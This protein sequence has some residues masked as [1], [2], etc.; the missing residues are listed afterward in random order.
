MTLRSRLRRRLLIGAAGAT[1][2]LTTLGVAAPAQAAYT[3]GLQQYAGTAGCAMTFASDVCAQTP[4]SLSGQGI[5]RDGD[6]LYLSVGDDNGGAP[7]LFHYRRTAGGITLASCVVSV[8]SEQTDALGCEVVSFL[9]RYATRPA[10]AEDAVYIGGS[11]GEQG[12]TWSGVVAAIPRD[13]ATGDLVALGATC[14]AANA[15]DAPGCT[16]AGLDRLGTD[17]ADVVVAPD[18]LTVHALASTGPETQLV[19]YERV[20]GP[21]NEPGALDPVSC[22][23]NVD[24]SCDRPPANQRVLLNRGNE[25]AIAP[26]GA[27]VYL[28]AQNG[29]VHLARN[30]STGELSIDDCVGDGDDVK[31]LCDKGPGDFLGVS[32]LSMSSDDQVIAIAQGGDSVSVVRLL[33]DAS[34]TLTEAGCIGTAEEDGCGVAVGVISPEAAVATPDDKNVI[35]SNGAGQPLVTLIAGGASGLRPMVGS[36]GCITG[37]QAQPAGCPAD[38]RGGTVREFAPSFPTQ[39]LATDA[40]VVVTNP[41]SMLFFVR[42]RAPGCLQRSATAARPSGALPLV[43]TDPNGD[44]I[45]LVIGR[46]PAHGTLDEISQSGSNVVFTP[47]DTYEGADS[48]TYGAGDGTFTSTAVTY[49]LILPTGPNTVKPTTPTAPTTPPLDDGSN[50]GGGKATDDEPSDKGNGGGG[51][52]VAPGTI[53]TPAPSTPGPTAGPS[54]IDLKTVGKQLTVSSKRIVAFKL[55]CKGEQGAPACKGALRLGAASRLVVDGKRQVVTFGRKD[56]VIP[57]GATFTVSL[58]LTPKLAALITKKRP[59]AAKVLAIGSAPSSATPVAATVT[60]KR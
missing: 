47:D 52:D 48:F 30:D 34:G 33:R 51:Q 40:E 26:D 23:A 55:T 27:D 60:L 39:I 14:H 44:Q 25:L 22:L 43:C 16:A 28:A 41:Y 35:I 37:E 13:P 7:G 18:G 31:A 59:V 3:P 4:G 53:N 58:R 46:Q 38:L 29:L 57:A 8:A 11:S 6:D 42:G 2:I 24:V 45:A 10:L 1:A 54:T 12:G 21:M 19:T 17:V 15:S 49:S 36:T 32:R 5:A 20:T 50:G 56:Y 9:P